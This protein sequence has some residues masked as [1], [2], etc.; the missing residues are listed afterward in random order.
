MHEV[1]KVNMVVRNTRFRYPITSE[2]VGDTFDEV[3]NTL[4]DLLGY[5]NNAG[6][7]AVS[8]ELRELWD[9]IDDSRA[10]S[11]GSTAS[12]VNE[13]YSYSSGVLSNRL[14]VYYN[15]LDKLGAILDNIVGD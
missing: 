13:A 1:N 9:D 4:V 12:G 10:S 7:I 15:K 11:F 8:G 3:Y 5:Q 14:T 6:V 2:Q